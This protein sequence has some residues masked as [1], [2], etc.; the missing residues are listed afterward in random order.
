MRNYARFHRFIPVRDNLG[1]ELWIGN[2]QGV[3]YLYDFSGFPLRDPAEYNRLGE[4]RFMES[5]RA[6]ALRFIRQ[7]PRTFLRLSAERCFAYWTSPSPYL[8]LPFSLLAWLGVVVFYRRTGAKAVPFALV[9][10]VFP[11]IYYVTHPWPTYRHP[12]EPVM[13]LGAAYAG[14]AF[15]KRLGRGVGRGSLAGLDLPATHPG[16]SGG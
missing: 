1:L 7:H 6:I 5:R 11:V 10:V 16:A 3:T 9:L 12:T 15:A 8:W 13:L 4:L 2:H 14:V